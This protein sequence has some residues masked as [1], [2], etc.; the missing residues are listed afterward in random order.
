MR[1]LKPRHP[2]LVLL[3]L[4]LA[5]GGCVTETSRGDGGR[6]SA[7]RPAKASVWTR[8]ELYF[9]GIATEPWDQFLA[10]V[11]TPKFP[12][13]LTVLDAHGQWLGRDAEVHRLPTRILLILHPGTTTTD[14]TLE[15]IRRE[16]KARFHHESVLR[17][18]S[19]A[20]VSF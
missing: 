1:I 13:G 19:P 3:L 4:A 9:G 11:V 12:A 14:A 5:V 15:D 2:L 8:T 18:D 7:E 16:F 6:L 17:I 20:K 10:E